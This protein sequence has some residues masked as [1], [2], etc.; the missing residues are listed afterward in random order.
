[1]ST[2]RTPWFE[3]DALMAA[4][5]AA[6]VLAVA[7][8]FAHLWLKRREYAEAYRGYAAFL[9]APWKLGFFAL[10]T[11]V[12]T[13]MAPYTTD[14]TWDRIDAPLM[15]TLSYFSAAWVLGVLYRWRRTP[16]AHLAVAAC[17][18]M[19]SASWCYDGYLLFRDGT[20]PITWWSNILASSILYIIVGLV[21]NL[22]VRP[23]R[24]ATFAFMEPTWLLPPAP[25]ATVRILLWTLPFALLGTASLAY[26]VDWG[27]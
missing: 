1:M 26:F 24:G 18:W 7:L 2:F 14:P 25:G 4:Y 5:L 11:L 6:W 23:G 17:L 9:L 21:W 12:I 20:Y 16:L 13:V 10:A 8:A 27:P 22:D 15:A 19:L 3:L